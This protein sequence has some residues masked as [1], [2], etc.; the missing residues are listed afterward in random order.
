MRRILMQVVVLAAFTSAAVARAEPPVKEGTAVKAPRQPVKS[1]AERAAE[2]KAIEQQHCSN[3]VS[4]PQVRAQPAPAARD[5]LL[6][7]PAEQ[8][9]ALK[10]ALAPGTWSPPQVSAEKVREKAKVSPWDLLRTALEELSP[11]DQEKLTALMRKV[12]VNVQSAVQ[13]RRAKEK[14]NGSRG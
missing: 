12:A 4:A 2:A 13:P 1:A 5:P 8:K 11:A 14:A 3:D 7:Y 9:A 6:R 10:Q